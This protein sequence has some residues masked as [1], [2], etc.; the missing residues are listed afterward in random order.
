MDEDEDKTKRDEMKSPYPLVV[1]L[2]QQADE[3][4]DKAKRAGAEGPNVFEYFH[5]TK[6]AEV[7]VPNPTPQL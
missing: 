3:D 7:E 5:P 6:R 1:Y 2:P 4:E